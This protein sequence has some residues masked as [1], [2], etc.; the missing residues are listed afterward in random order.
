[1]TVLLKAFQNVSGHR[2]R[3][4]ISTISPFPENYNGLYMRGELK[5]NT[6]CLLK[7]I[8]KSTEQNIPCNKAQAKQYSEYIG[9]MRI[10]NSRY[11]K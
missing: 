4:S 2:P 9:S 11:K 3:L 1:M 8:A 7:C 10:C 6:V 5:S